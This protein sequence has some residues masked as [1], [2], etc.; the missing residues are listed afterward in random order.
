LQVKSSDDL[1]DPRTSG[2]QQATTY[3]E[4]IPL[5]WVDTMVFMPLR[6]LLTEQDPETLEISDR[7]LSR[8]TSK[9]LVSSVSAADF[10]ARVSF[11]DCVEDTPVSKTE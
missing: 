7:L 8:D 2:G 3:E 6:T 5:Q 1:R 11:K 9:E 10:L 4:F